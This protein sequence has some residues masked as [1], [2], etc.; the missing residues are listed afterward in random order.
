[1]IRVAI[2]G[3]GIGAEHL[4][5]YRALPDLFEV[6]VIC[7]L[8]AARA[9]SIAG[10]IPVSTDSDEVIHDPQIDLIDICLPPH[11]HVPISLKA[12][13]A[14][15]HVIC[16]KPLA[17]SLADIDQLERA[18]GASK[19][20]LFPV[21]QYRFG[22]AMDQLVALQNAGLL[23]QPHMASLETH[24]ARDAAYYAVPWRG[25]WAGECGGAVV[26]HAIHA[27]DLLSH[28]FGGI[29]TVNARLA[30]RINPIETEDCAALSFTLQNGALAT[31]SVTLGGSDDTTRI[32]LIYAGLTATSG[33]RP[34][35]PMDQEWTFQARDPALQSQVDQI[36]QAV[37]QTRAGFAGMLA[38]VASAISGAPNSAVRLA[39]ARA[40]IE[41]ITAIY[42]SSRAEGRAVSCPVPPNHPLYHGW[43]HTAD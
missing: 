5:G 1:M 11:L 16:E 9:Q 20:T 15:K 39:D 36:T 23:G 29:K 21:F 7:D 3:A 2:L 41:L 12:L 30:T 18:E 42:A 22:R 33:P 14:N 37:L 43:I 38:Q 10:K 24:W 19:G 31:S 8:D 27:H 40:S 4:A 34:Y 25:T 35:A 17:T 28:L 6:V 26:G 32:R 13:A